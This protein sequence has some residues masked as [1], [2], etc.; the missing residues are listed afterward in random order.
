MKKKNN[1]Y[2][3]GTSIS[4]QISRQQLSTAARFVFYP[5]L[6]PSQ[7]GIPLTSVIEEMPLPSGIFR[8][9]FG[10]YSWSPN[11]KLGRHRLIPCEP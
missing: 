7:G 11:T 10:G 4:P 1:L 2:L 6:P 9:R 5:K 3:P 8:G